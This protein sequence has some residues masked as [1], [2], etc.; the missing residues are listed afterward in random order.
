VKKH[1]VLEQICKFALVDFGHA[2]RGVFFLP[3]FLSLFSSFYYLIF[4]F[5]FDYD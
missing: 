2:G 1:Y 3:F 4:L 5:S